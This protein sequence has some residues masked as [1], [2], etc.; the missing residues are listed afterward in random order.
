GDRVLRCELLLSLGDALWGAG[1]RPGMREAYQHAAEA[2]RDLAPGEAAA[3]LARAALGL[4]GRRLYT[5]SVLFDSV[6]VPLLEEA[7]TML[8]PE[9]SALRARVLA[10][11]AYS[12]YMQ[13]RSGELCEG[14]CAEA[15]VMARRIGDPE[16]L[17]WVL[18]D[19]RWTLWGPES[20]DERLRV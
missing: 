20:I 8:G 4:S 1:D 18:N 14:L 3:R 16:T 15:E 10:R 2:A 5:P 19:R 6:V 17:R 7:L 12:L 11:L 9:D 13:P